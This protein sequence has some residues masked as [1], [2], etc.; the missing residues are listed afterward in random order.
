M[1]DVIAK[2]VGA[3][4]F[5]PVKKYYQTHKFE[6]RKHLVEAYEH[7]KQE[8]PDATRARI[9]AKFQKATNND[10]L[11]WRSIHRWSHQC[12]MNKPRSEGQRAL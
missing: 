12:V 2:V 10:K 1:E 11:K 7:L 6:T 4:I 8:E 9:I 5:G 3:D